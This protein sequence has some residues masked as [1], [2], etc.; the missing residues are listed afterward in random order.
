MT[1][2]L[3][4]CLLLLV[5]WCCLLFG[6]V[7]CCLLLF[8]VVC[9]CLLL[10]GVIWCYL[11]LFGVVDDEV[12]TTGGLIPFFPAA[13]FHKVTSSQQETKDTAPIVIA[14]DIIVA[15]QPMEWC[16]NTTKI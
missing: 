2:H 11:V 7:W 6:V 1:K 12:F 9:C 13:I 8:V 5:V 15:R 10:F 16:H 14:H 4:C 3:C